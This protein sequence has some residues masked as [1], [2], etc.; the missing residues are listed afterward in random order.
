M[1]CVF[2]ILFFHLFLS[3]A[4][5]LFGYLV[6]SCRYTS[7]NSRHPVYVMEVIAN[8]VRVIEYNST[9]ERCVGYTKL[10]KTIAEILNHDQRFIKL[11]KRNAEI[12]SYFPEILDTIMQTVEPRAWVHSVEAEDGK[13]AAMLVCSVNNFF[14]KEIKVT[15]LRNGK[16]VTS[17]VTNTDVLA[18]GNW[19]YQIHSFL[20]YTPKPGDTVTCVVDH[21]SLVQPM[22]KNWEPFTEPEKMK[23]AVGSFAILM[24]LGVFLAGLIY[25]INKPE[26]WL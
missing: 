22:L 10:G 23:I 15:W 19:R 25:H 7:D 3:S 2:T 24:G 12:C 16:N 1:S 5:A 4:G 9:L 6:L 21:A 26:P 8:H 20:E 13:H 11:E 14:P 17:G 18:D